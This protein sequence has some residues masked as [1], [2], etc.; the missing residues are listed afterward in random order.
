MITNLLTYGISED[1][2]VAIYNLTKSPKI[3][4]VSDIADGTKL[5]LKAVAFFTDINEDRE[6][7]TNIVSVMTKE[8]VVYATNSATFSRELK[9]IISIFEGNIDF[10]IEKLSGVT[11]SNRTF[12]NCALA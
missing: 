2:K 7:E 10:K 9:D 11:K 4:K 12:V 6:T 1:D 3:E 5:D 8:G